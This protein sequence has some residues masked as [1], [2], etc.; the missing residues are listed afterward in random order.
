MPRYK[1]L[2]TFGRIFKVVNWSVANFFVVKIGL[3]TECLIVIF[4]Q[5][6]M[7]ILITNHLS[8]VIWFSIKIRDYNTDKYNPP[9]PHNTVERWH[10]VFFDHYS[11]KYLKEK[12]NRQKMIQYCSEAK[13]P[14]KQKK[15][16]DTNER[17]T[18]IC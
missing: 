10:F 8:Q 1:F 3:K 15:Y 16:K 7:L 11:P 9:K 5:M 17:I 6:T 2:N 4:N 14:S 13:P 18:K 12:L